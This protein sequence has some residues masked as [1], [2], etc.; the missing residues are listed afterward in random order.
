MPRLGICTWYGPRFAHTNDEATKLKGLN[1]LVF[2]WPRL[3]EKFGKY[4]FDPLL[5]LAHS[6]SLRSTA[7][8]LS[9]D[10]EL[11]YVLCTKYICRRTEKNMQNLFRHFS[12]RRRCKATK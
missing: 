1:V 4:T 5:D 6:V 9:Y 11:D 2:R 10:S 3:F 12:F 7:R 8:I